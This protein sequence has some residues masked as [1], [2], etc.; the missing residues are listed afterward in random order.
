LNVKSITTILL[1]AAALALGWCARGWLS[2]PSP[3]VYEVTAIVRDT[4]RGDSV[5]YVVRVPLP[6]VRYVQ[7]A[8]DTVR[9]DVDTAAILAD[10]FATRYYRDTIVNDSEALIA[11]S[12][13]VSQNSLVERSLTFQNRRATSI[14]TTI[15]QPPPPK[16]RLYVGAV[17]GRGLTAPTVQVA[18]RRWSLGA[19]YNLSGG[20][21]IGSVGYMVDFR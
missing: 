3:Q 6:V 17:A 16:V 1:F 14:T 15:V 2:S 21:F 12:E 13:E 10:Y 18:Y 8:P 7:L 11:I 19:G 5:P 20:G 9:I 4:V